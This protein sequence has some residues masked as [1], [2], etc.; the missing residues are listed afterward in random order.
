MDG[1]M[2]GWM[3]G[4]VVC[5][6][7]TL[8]FN[9]VSL[10]LFLRRIQRSFALHTWCAC[11]FVRF[12]VLLLALARAVAH[13]PAAR[14]TGKRLLPG[15]LC[16]LAK[17]AV[18]DGGLARH[19]LAEFPFLARIACGFVHFP[20]ETLTFFGAVTDALAAPTPEESSPPI[21]TAR[22]CPCGCIAPA[23]RC[24]A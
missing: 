2:D 1:W 20:V 10:A 16:S 13:R 23:A 9:H 14:T 22:A 21:T 15:F 5:S 19:L 8:C 24:H 18:L 17:V 4:P 12:P 6:L 7:A 3:D 11:V